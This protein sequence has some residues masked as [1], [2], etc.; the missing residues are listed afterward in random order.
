MSRRCGMSGR[1][2]YNVEVCRNEVIAA[3]FAERNGKLN[4]G[5]VKV[6]C[7]SEDDDALCTHSYMVGQAQLHQIQISTRRLSDT[8]EFAISQRGIQTRTPV[9]H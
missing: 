2:D 5:Q 7:V 9:A 4:D 6:F 8:A 3:V 1:E